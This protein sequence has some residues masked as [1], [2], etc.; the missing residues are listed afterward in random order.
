MASSNYIS[1]L[2]RRHGLPPSQLCTW[3]RLDRSIPL[4]ASL[5]SSF[6][7]RA[8]RP[9]KGERRREYWDTNLPNFALVVTP[10]GTKSFIIEYRL[11]DS[12]GM[13]HH[14]RY[15]IGQY[16]P[17]WSLEKARDEARR[18]FVFIKAGIDPREERKAHKRRAITRERRVSLDRDRN[19]LLSHL[20]RR[21][22]HR[23]QEGISDQTKIKQE[24]DILENLVSEI[25]D[26]SVRH[27]S[28][29]DYARGSAEVIEIGQWSRSDVDRVVSIFIDWLR[30][31]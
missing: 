4:R 10:R 2:F 15:T 12:N 18:L 9:I 16:G 19:D 31:E 23:N 1:A 28:E 5:S 6:V 14:V 26:R 24:R 11:A 7:N 25:G 3:R 20:V 17:E 8:P 27:L 22:I 13:V 30:S 29:S 21:Y